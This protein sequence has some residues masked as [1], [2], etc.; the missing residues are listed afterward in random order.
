MGRLPQV[1]P[2]QAD[3]DRGVASASASA[4]DSAARALP[5]PEK[6]IER[7]RDAI[8]QAALSSLR[9]TLHLVFRE[10]PLWRANFVTFGK[11][12]NTYV[13]LGN[14]IFFPYLFHSL[15]FPTSLTRQ[16]FGWALA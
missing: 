13:K 6:G 15:C 3:A 10:F 8:E 14:T 2:H 4:G 7:V 12:G 11:R 9:L 16:R 5:P 1:Q